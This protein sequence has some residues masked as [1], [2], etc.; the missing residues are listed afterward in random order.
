MLGVTQ[1][2]LV[3]VVET[4]LQGFIEGFVVLC[5][6]EIICMQFLAVFWSHIQKQ[7]TF[8][9]LMLQANF[10]CVCVG[11]HKVHVCLT[12]HQG[13]IKAQT[14]ARCGQHIPPLKA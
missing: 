10:V 14:G 3:F 1:I 2:C 4:V 11:V 12:T 7:I 6:T 13:Y 8:H 9:N 5:K